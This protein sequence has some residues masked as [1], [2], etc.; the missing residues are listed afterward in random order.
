[1]RKTIKIFFFFFFSSKRNKP[2]ENLTIP[3]ETE[4]REKKNKGK[5][6]KENSSM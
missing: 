2:G 1:M 6:Q 4:K 5:Y 3:Q